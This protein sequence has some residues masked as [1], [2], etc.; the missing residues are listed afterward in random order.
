MLETKENKVKIEGVLS[1]VQIDFGEFTKRDGSK[2]KSIGGLIKVRVNQTINGTAQELEVP[3]HMFASELTNSGAPNPA[4]ESIRRIKEEYVSIA[5]AGG[6]EGADCVRIT[7]GQ[8]QMNEYYG[9]T[10][11]L[12][13]FPRVTSSFVTKI[14]KE[15]C[16]PEATFSVI[17]VVGKKGFDTDKDGIEIKDRYKICGIIPQWGGKVDVVEFLAV[18]P[19]VIDAV[20]SYWQE[21]DTV[22]ANGRLNFTSRTE[23]HT[24][25]VDFGEPTVETRTISVSELVITGGS[26]TPLEGDF[27]YDN[28][29]ISS[30]LADRQNRLSEMKERAK[31]R[32]N[33]SSKAAPAPA[34]KTSFANLGF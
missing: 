13:S 31:N 12:V 2:M 24:V 8:I 14:K 30:A 25:E 1:E 23:E 11:K 19:G 27:A 3:V 6:I 10:G 21:G 29:E 33:G 9:Q 28:G 4:Y 32:A 18:A 16:H 17:F 26:Q 34:A 22:K 15:E 5:A 20:S 7:G